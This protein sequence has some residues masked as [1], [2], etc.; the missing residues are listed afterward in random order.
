M[1]VATQTQ[2][3]TTTIEDLKAKVGHLK[4]NPSVDLR[5][6]A[7]VESTPF[8]GTEFRSYS[9]KGEP[10]LTIREVLK[11]EA[12]LAALGRLV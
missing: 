11:D 10:I 12:K 8:I 2:T 1:P 3:Q 7:H 5:Q 6:Y 4:L 9:K